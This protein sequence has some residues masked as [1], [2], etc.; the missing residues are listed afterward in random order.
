MLPTVG[1]E[2][3]RAL[4]DNGSTTRLHRVRGSSILPGSTNG[5]IGD[6]SGSTCLPPERWCRLCPGCQS[7]AFGL[8]VQRKNACMACRRQEF[9]SPLV[10]HLR[11]LLAPRSP[12]GERSLCIGV[13]SL[14]LPWVAPRQAAKRALP[15]AC[16]SP[17]PSSTTAERHQVYHACWSPEPVSPWEMIKVIAFALIVHQQYTALSMRRARSITEWGRHFPVRS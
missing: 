3:S 11:T 12:R 14:N 4:G 10:H 15:R 9:D 6:H 8:V 17:Q 1:G 16:W 13:P 5:C 2:P 7:V